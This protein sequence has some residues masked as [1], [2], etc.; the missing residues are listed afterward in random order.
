MTGTTELQT[1]G[2]VFDE[3]RP[4]AAGVRLVTA[5]TS[6]RP[7][8]LAWI[9]RVVNVG[10]GMPVYGMSGATGQVK[11]HD[12]LFGKVVFRKLDLAIE[13]REH[14]SALVHRV[15]HAG[16]MALR[17]KCIALGPQQFWALA[18]VRIVT[19]RT[20]LFEHRLV[21][22][23]LVL[24]FS[25]IGVAIQADVDRILLGIA[26]RLA[27]MG[28]MAVC[29]IALGAFMFELRGF[30]SGGL[31]R[32]TARAECLDVLLREH[33]FA[34][35]GGRVADIAELLAEWWMQERLHQLGATRLVRIV[36]AHAIGFR[37][38]LPLV[39]LN[40]GRV[41][42]VVAIQAKRRST[43]GEMEG[44]LRIR[45][46]PAFVSCMARVAS[47]VESFVTAA[48]LWNTH[49]GLVA[50]QAEIFLCGNARRR[51]QQFVLGGRGVRI[52]TG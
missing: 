7:L 3:H 14:M 1:R 8:D 10:N 19:G 52:V 49:P 27:G 12:L 28:V 22:D 34:I 11:A 38:R 9:S 5:E 24:Q 4:R 46:V 32:M 42:G 31:L 21:Q 43:L 36:A 39:S 33:D 50:T 18:T 2:K 35:Q 26:S 29:A 25:L 37:K 30:N 13:D 23:P 15:T 51:L 48:A 44:K 16:A 20:T 45:S 17:A 41:S 40:Q 47:Q 6:Q